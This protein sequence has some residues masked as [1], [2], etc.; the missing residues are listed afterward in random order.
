MLIGNHSQVYSFAPWCG[1]C[2]QIAPMWEDLATQ[3]E[4]T[5]YQVGE[6]DCTKYPLVC[7]RQKV[8]G[9]PTI[10]WFD[11][12]VSKVYAGP[13]DAN[14]I[15]DWINRG[16]PSQDALVK[17]QKV[18]KKEVEV[19][20]LT[21]DNFDQVLEGI[22]MVNFYAS[23]CTHS[24]RLEPV[25]KE[26]ATH[27]VDYRVAS[28]DISTEHEFA[29]QYDVRGTPTILLF[30]NGKYF[31]FAGSRSV[32]FLDRF[33]R[34]EGLG[35]DFEADIRK[36][37][38]DAEYVQST[39]VDFTEHFD[40]SIIQMDVFVMFYAPWCGHCKQLAPL[41]ERLGEQVNLAEVKTRKI[42]K[43]DCTKNRAVI[44]KYSIRSYPTLI[45]FKKNGEEIH[46]IGN[47]DVDSLY[48]F[49]LEHSEE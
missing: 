49:L 21:R 43:V 7:G 20:K 48:E 40:K 46:Y 14:A 19:V 1:H 36:P 8:S 5:N 45:L 25:W 35:E 29:A 41:W 23:W 47:K 18:A 13:R 16:A 15:I 30:K 11:E 34:S 2:K 37:P 9:Y 27:A 32:D 4:G 42:A 33:A 44:D 31:R 12:G 17:D 39:V 6:V 28:M 3:S 26:L 24:K 22:W 38:K 10:K